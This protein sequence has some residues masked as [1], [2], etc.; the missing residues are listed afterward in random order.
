MLFGTTPAKSFRQLSPT[1]ISA[2]APAGVGKIHVTVM[3]RAGVTALVRKGVFA[4]NVIPVIDRLA[5]PAGPSSGHNVVVIIGT[6]LTGATA[7]HFGAQA[8]R[9]FQV[10][11]S[12]RIKVTVPPGQGVVTV[13]VT[14]RA[15]VS[16]SSAT[17]RYHYR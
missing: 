9:S 16:R 3:T 2:V 7:L 4:F 1:R 10:R 12:T 17:T 8:A 15:G 14:T 11:S 5:P 6:G 13:T